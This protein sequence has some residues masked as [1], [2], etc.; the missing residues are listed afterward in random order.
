MAVNTRVVPTVGVN[1][2]TIFG[3]ENLIGKAIFSMWFQVCA[4]RPTVQ[5]S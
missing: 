1:A 2:H 3:K 4:K 5:I